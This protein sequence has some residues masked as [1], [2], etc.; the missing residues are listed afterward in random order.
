MNDETVL[1]LLLKISDFDS[2]GW[3]WVPKSGDIVLALQE[4][5]SRKG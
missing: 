1:K 4:L 5:R 2:K 3:D